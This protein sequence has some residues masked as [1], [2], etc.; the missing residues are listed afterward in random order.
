M[1]KRSLIS[2]IVVLMTAGTALADDWI[3][4]WIQQA[5]TSGPNMFESQKR[6]YASAGSLSLRFGNEKDYLVNVSPPRCRAGCGGI[7]MFMGS[8]AYLE[9]EYLMEK[10]E[11]IAEGGMATFVFDIAMSVLSEPI[12][13]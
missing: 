3:D 12:Q 8:F 4:N 10:L 5:T 9:A 1:F 7:D 2:V 11:R 6:G 13:K